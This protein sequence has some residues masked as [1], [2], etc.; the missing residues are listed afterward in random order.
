MA[1]L[2][3]SKDRAPR[4]ALGLPGGLRIFREGLQAVGNLIHHRLQEAVEAP[5]CRRAGGCRRVATGEGGRVR[6]VV[7]V[8]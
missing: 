8:V 4:F 5:K 7:G 1:P 3:G 6:A 2:I